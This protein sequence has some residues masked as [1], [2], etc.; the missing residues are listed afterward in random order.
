M[1]FFQDDMTFSQYT[2][3]YTIIV[4]PAE[5]EYSHFSADFRLKLF[6]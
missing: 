1:S 5:A 4:F 2:L 3:F 6:L